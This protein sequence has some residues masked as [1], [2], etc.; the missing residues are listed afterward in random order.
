MGTGQRAI[1]LDCLVTSMGT[2]GPECNRT[3]EQSGGCPLQGGC[4]LQPHPHLCCP[5]HMAIGGCPVTSFLPC[6]FESHVAGAPTACLPQ[7]W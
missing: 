4:H 2:T 1:L 7:L 6:L 5:L 3:L